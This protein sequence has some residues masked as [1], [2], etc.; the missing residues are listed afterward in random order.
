MFHL[1]LVVGSRAGWTFAEG[2]SENFTTSV[3]FPLLCSAA[4][5][6]QP[7]VH[8]FERPAVSSLL[9]GERQAG[10]G[11][12]QGQAMK[13]GNTGIGNTIPTQ[14]EE[15]IADTVPIWPGNGRRSP[16]VVETALWF[17]V[18]HLSPF[19][20]PLC[21]PPLPCRSWG[22]SSSGRSRRPR[23]VDTGLG[24]EGLGAEAPPAFE[25]PSPA[26]GS[27]LAKVKL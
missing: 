25:P 24:C 16:K 5:S 18:R 13:D 26:P 14:G 3:R 6:H 7:E 4:Q 9:R 20:K 21:D 15:T 12:L 10:S 2:L 11:T 1:L 23:E 22:C 17:K 19:F 27:L 8:D